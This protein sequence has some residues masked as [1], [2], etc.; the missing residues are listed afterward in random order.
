MSN[1][2]GSSS[3]STNVRERGRIVGVPKRCWCGETIVAKTSKSDHNPN[4]R[5]LRCVY[6]AGN[7]LMNDNHV[8]KWVD[9]ALLDEVETMKE[10]ISETMKE[11]KMQ[12]ELQMEL[13]K[14]MVMEVEK[15]IFER[16]EDVKDEF[17][18]RMNRMIIVLVFGC[19]I[20]IGLV[21]LI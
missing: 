3:C 1:I 18:S 20:M 16:I 12:M 2:S 4:R 9:D 5:Y 6:A 7:K 19:M 21:K 15:E 14:K 8:F 11:K 10:F 13:E 17:K